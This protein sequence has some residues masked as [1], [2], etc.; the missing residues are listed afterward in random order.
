MQISGVDLT[1]DRLRKL[2]GLGAL[3]GVTAGGVAL[4]RG[5][6]QRRAYSPEQ[7]RQRLRARHA[8]TVDHEGPAVVGAPG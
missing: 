8:E 2:L 5:E 7:V 1:R 3:L 4:A 6:R